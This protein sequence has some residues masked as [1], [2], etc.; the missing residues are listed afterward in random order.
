MMSSVVLITGAST[1]FGRLAAE[2]LAK[3]GH[4]V[5]ATMRDLAGRNAANRD[6]L[7]SFADSTKLQLHVLELEVTDGGSDESAVQSVLE[8]AARID[9]VI[10]NAR[11]AAIGV[12]EAYTIEQFQ[13]LFDTNVYGPLRMNRAVL[14]HM[15]RQRSGLLIHVSSAAGR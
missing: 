7:V 8:Q 12:T 5:F 10:N 1:G 9:V 15:R 2:K 3:R 14:P 13:T 11:F 4:T 6:E